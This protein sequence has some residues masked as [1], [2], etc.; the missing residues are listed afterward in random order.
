[1]G[2]DPKARKH[3]ESGISWH[4]LENGS[5]G[6]AHCFGDLGMI[7]LSKFVGRKGLNYRITSWWPNWGDFDNMLVR[8][9]QRIQWCNLTIRRIKEVPN[10]SLITYLWWMSFSD[11]TWTSPQGKTLL[12]YDQTIQIW[13]HAVAI[14]TVVLVTAVVF[15]LGLKSPW[16]CPRSKALKSE[17]RRIPETTLTINEVKIR[18]RNLQY[19]NDN[20]T[21][22][23]ISYIT[24]THL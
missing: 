7:I 16:N 17:S 11:V 1:M 12:Q 5:A 18:T 15:R 23:V 6:S 19:R 10:V 8:P 13:W 3:W 21:G 14:V 20:G 24:V 2:Q 22:T 9:W 4:K